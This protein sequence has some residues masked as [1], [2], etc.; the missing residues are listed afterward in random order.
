MQPSQHMAEAAK[1][2]IAKPFPP[3]SYLSFLWENNV[4]LIAS[5]LTNVGMRC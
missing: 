3:H 5:P 4:I 1:E 2:A